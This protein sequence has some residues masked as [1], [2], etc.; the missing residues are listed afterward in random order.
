MIAHD[1]PGYDLCRPDDPSPK[2]ITSQQGGK[3]PLPIRIPAITEPQ[4]SSIK[5]DTPSCPAFI[6][7]IQ[8]H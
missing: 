5:L 2:T 7:V 3:S 4:P 6:F 8:H 1:G